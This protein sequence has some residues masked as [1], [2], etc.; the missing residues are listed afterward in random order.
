MLTYV[1]VNV[2]TVVSSGL[3]KLP[4]LC[5][6]NQK[7]LTEKNAIVH[8]QTDLARAFIIMLRHKAKFTW[9][10]RKTLEKL[11]Q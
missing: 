6:F 5:F 3:Y 8:K 9:S 11:T 2:N 10:F 4:M 1:D 7:L